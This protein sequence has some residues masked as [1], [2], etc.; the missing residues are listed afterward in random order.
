MFLRNSGCGFTMNT[1]F[2]NFVSKEYELNLSEQS[3]K[4]LTS[5]LR[6]FYKHLSWRWKKSNRT[7]KIFTT[8]YESWLE[9][10]YELPYDLYSISTHESASTSSSSDNKPFDDITDRHKRRRT[11][12][13]R[14]SNSADILLYAAKQKLSSDGSSDFAKVLDYLIKNP[15]NIERVR[16]FCENKFKTPLLSKEKCLALFLSLNLSKQQYIELRQT[17]IDNGTNQWRSYYEIQQTKAE[18]YPPKN[19]ITETFA[20]IELQALLDHTTTRLLQVCKENVNLHTNLTLICKWG[21]DGASNQ[22]TYKQHFVNENALDSSVFVTSLVPIKLTNGS[23]IIWMNEYPSST[24]Y[25]RPI[26]FHFTHENAEI[27]KKEYERMEHEINNLISTKCGNV[28]VNY[29]MLFT[30]IDGKVCTILSNVPSS[31]SCYLCGAKPTEMNNIDKVVMRDVDEKTYNFG[32]SSLHAKIRCMEFLLHVSY[33]LEFKKW[34]VREPYMKK[35]Q[36]ETKK[37]IQEQFKKDMNLLVDVIKQGSGLTNDGNTARRFFSDIKTTAKITGLNETLIKNFAI[38]LQ[39]IS[40]GEMIDAKK[41]GHFAIETAKLFVQNYGWYYMSPSVHKLLVHGEAIISHFSVP[42]G[43]LSEEASEARN[44]EFR[45][46]RKD[47][48]R[49]I[50]R[51]ATNEDLLNHLLLT[52]DPLISN[53]RPKHN[54]G[55]R[56]DLFS[57]TRELLK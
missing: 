7:L 30:M 13:L 17:C 35:Q 6:L 45:Q 43:H 27:C 41:F 37:K 50:S 52:S 46:Y 39:A 51:T 53:L 3:E 10:V 29:D 26:R 14:A 21:F 36:A 16:D 12:D 23:D 38:I 49:K 56:Q 28:T 54:E 2:I 11:A 25:C 55:K 1:N 44:K 22:S 20:F 48:T 19:K 42:I 5:S 4:S 47:H 8:K 34:S 18:C 57:E 24:R 15:T 33:N 31:S 40:C 32:I 9:K